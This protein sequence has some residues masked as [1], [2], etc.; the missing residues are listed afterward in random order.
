MTALKNQIHHRDPEDAGNSIFK[1][2]HFPMVF[3]NFIVIAEVAR[4]RLD[5]NLRVFV[6]FYFHDGVQGFQMWPFYS[7]WRLWQLG[8]KI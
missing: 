3:R 5:Q 6:V 2:V 1:S 7:K 8:Q 4:Q